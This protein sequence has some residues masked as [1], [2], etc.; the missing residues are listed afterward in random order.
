MGH[1][2]TKEE[3]IMV[4]QAVERYNKIMMNGHK[5]N[6]NESKVNGRYNSYLKRH[7]GFILNLENLENLE[8]R[9]FLR[10]VRENLE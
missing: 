2:R 3:R 6:D 5:T 9:Q 4:R 10:K 7:T 1:Y 8:N